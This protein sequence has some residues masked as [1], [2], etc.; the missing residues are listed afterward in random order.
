[1]RVDYVREDTLDA[2]LE[3]LRGVLSKLPERNIELDASDSFST[4]LGV[5]KAG[6]LLPS[7]SPAWQPFSLSASR[8]AQAQQSLQLALKVQAN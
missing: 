8:R 1:M 5:P 6:L 4:A 2:L 7:S 3:Q